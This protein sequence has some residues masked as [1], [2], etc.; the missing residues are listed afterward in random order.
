VTNFAVDPTAV[1]GDSQAAAVKKFKIET[2]TA[3]GPFKVSIN[4][5]TALPLG[6]FTTLHPATGTASNVLFVRFTMISNRGD[7]SFMDMTELE[8]HGT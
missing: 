4:R 6:G 1:C 2:K 8:V 3:S 5:S 7:A